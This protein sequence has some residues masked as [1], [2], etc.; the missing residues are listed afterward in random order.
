V[1][2]GIGRTRRRKTSA[3]GAAYTRSNEPACALASETMELER[4]FKAEG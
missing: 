2:A 1:R 4:K 3:V